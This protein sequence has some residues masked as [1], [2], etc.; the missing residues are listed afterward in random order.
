MPIHTQLHLSDEHKVAIWKI[1]E[2]VDDLL[3]SLYISASDKETLSG[4]KLDR[5]KKEWLATR[6]LLQG[7]LGEY[8]NIVYGTNGKPQLAGHDCYI[9]ISHTSNY[10]AVSVSN[11]PTALDIEIC[12]N[13][14][15]K[16]A[17]R[18][19]HKTEWEYIQDTDKLQYYTTLW[20]AKE[21]LY[22]YYNVYGVIFKE[23]FVV[24][25]FV[26]TG[27]G[28]LQST[29]IHKGTSK[30]LALNFLINDDF[31]LVYC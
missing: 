15:E 18:F 20:C 2:S 17:D 30:Q 4:F 9:S 6:L 13:R 26:L 7:L 8:P 21:A 29:F 25:S 5:R 19:V 1:D 10:A 28:N 24:S 12:S 23:Q 31:T 14:V 22:K 11:N 3:S 27:K 16:V